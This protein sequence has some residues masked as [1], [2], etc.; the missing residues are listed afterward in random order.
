MFKT[1]VGWTEGDPEP[2]NVLLTSHGLYIMAPTEQR[3]QGTA[4]RFHVH[5]HIS[6]RELDYV[7]V[8]THIL[9]V[10]FSQHFIC[11]TVLILS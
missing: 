11:S 10:N 4:G 2:V 8:N 3:G 1:L 6:Y 5:T 7:S 9:F